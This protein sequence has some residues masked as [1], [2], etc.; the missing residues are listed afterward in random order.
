MGAGQDYYSRQRR[1]RSPPPGC[2]SSSRPR[3]GH[4]PQA[5]RPP[6]VPSTPRGR[7][8]SRGRNSALA[9]SAPRGRSRSRP[10]MSG[11]FSGLVFYVGDHGTV[12]AK[13]AHVREEI[14]SNGGALCNYPRNKE[15]NVILVSA[16]PDEPFEIRT[17]S[18]C[19]DYDRRDRQ[20]WV[21]AGLIGA[22]AEMIDH[23]GRMVDRDIKTVL[24]WDW[25]LSCTRGGG[26]LGT[27]MDW[28]PFKV[29]G[30]YAYP[31]TKSLRL[32][33]SSTSASFSTNRSYTHSPFPHERLLFATSLN[34]VA[35]DRYLPR[36]P[37]LAARQVPCDSRL[38]DRQPPD[39]L[40]HLN[41]LPLAARMSWPGSN[42]STWSQDRST[43]PETPP[44]SSVPKT[45][46][47]HLLSKPQTPQ[48]PPTPS[49]LTLTGIDQSDEIK[50]EPDLEI[51]DDD[52][53]GIGSDLG[54]GDEAIL[55]NT[56]RPATGP[57]E[58]LIKPG[59]GV[60]THMAV[61]PMS[62][63]IK[64]RQ[65]EQDDVPVTTSDLGGKAKT[66][67]GD[68]EAGESS[69]AGKLA[70]GANS[71]TC[72]IEIV[73]DS[74]AEEED[75]NEPERTSVTPIIINRPLSPRSRSCTGSIDQVSAAAVQVTTAYSASS[76]APY[77][78]G[79]SNSG[80]DDKQPVF[81]HQ[82][83]PMTFYVPPEND[84][85]RL[86][87][88]NGGGRV[89]DTMKNVQ[90]IV[91]SRTRETAPS[92]PLGETEEMLVTTKESWQQ[93]IS[94]D[95][96]L[97]CILQRGLVPELPFLID[98]PRST[99]DRPSTSRASSS[100]RSS[101]GKFTSLPERLLLASLIT[102]Q[103]KTNSGKRQA[104][105][106]LQPSEAPKKS[107]NSLANSVATN[108]SSVSKAPADES[109]K[110]HSSQTAELEALKHLLALAL[111]NWDGSGTLSR[112]LND[113]RIKHPERRD[114]RKFHRRHRDDII[115]KLTTMKV[116]LA[117]IY[118]EQHKT[119]KSIRGKSQEE[120]AD[121]DDDDDAEW[122]GD[123]IIEC[124]DL[125]GSDEEY[126]E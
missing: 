13:V 46:E 3:R 49:A 41:P 118:G 48:S 47:H 120:E 66:E 117:S 94:S 5:D 112:F 100:A 116:D 102:T 97:Q 43:R 39:R 4:S 113:L 20:G 75:A 89:C 69:I 68:P 104:S 29:R 59:N 54:L 55:A 11:I 85:L 32:S 111:K 126:V 38:D 23:D 80:S 57:K 98:F 36:D 62:L 16:T 109:K 106:F 125:F 92:T 77:I 95:W 72:A 122:K 42:P 14:R 81:T 15:V 108:K 31:Q 93:A 103:L 51:N 83:V 10:R 21:T 2:R 9:S 71:I 124:D 6:L 76:R 88:V 63:T 56:E 114:W 30:K 28:E 110:K 37:R 105:T 119:S 58:S 12:T 79:F 70:I 60:V 25:I 17:R 115:A 121:D 53:E 61:T 73:T 52:L 91:I 34:P 44:L 33:I 50:P 90:R 107:R 67:Q 22:F 82:L 27:K 101:P 65:T 18:F 19:P 40:P 35:V 1:E 24:N 99:N 84:F 78:G 86:A 8:R 45:S 7:S 87:I 26:R 64:Q 123:E 74:E 96:I